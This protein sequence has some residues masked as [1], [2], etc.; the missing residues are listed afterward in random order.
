MFT[1]VSLRLPALLAALLLLVTMAA[2]DTDVSHVRIVRLSYVSG[3]VQVDQPGSAGSEKALLNMP[4]VEGMT[5]RTGDDGEAELE[6][7]S[8]TAVRVA[9][10]SQLDIPQLELQDGRKLTTV[11][12]ED[13]TAYVDYRQQRDSAFI[14]GY[15]S[16]QLTL[17]KTVRFR[18]EVDGNEL[19]LAVFKGSLDVA[20]TDRDVRV[21]KN[22]TATLFADDPERYELADSI[23]AGE[24]DDWNKEREQYVSYYSNEARQYNETYSYSYGASDLAYFGNSFY[25]PGYGYCWRPYGVGSGWDPFADGAWVWYPGFGYTWV[26]AYPWGWLPYRYGS[27]TFVPSY[28]WLWFPQGSTSPYTWR[29]GPNL[30]NPR[31]GYQPPKPPSA[32]GAVATAVA[33]GPTVVPVG[34]GGIGPVLPGHGQISPDQLAAI[35]ALRTKQGLAGT[36]LGQRMIL[37][38]RT[39]GEEGAVAA[40]R[41]GIG[42]AQPQPGVRTPGNEDNDAA[43]RAIRSRAGEENRPATAGRVEPAQ[44]RSMPAPRVDRSGPRPM[45]APRVER[46]EPRPAPMPS[47]RVERSEPRVYSPPPSPPPSAPARSAPAPSRPR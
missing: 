25:V 38:S 47:P 21:K 44:P 19:Q 20:G 10:G 22:E 5:I 37:R 34:R 15:G 4:V 23:A 35:Q 30:Y 9:P 17:D 32:S 31:P 7:E 8:G 29:T 26:S 40:G 14:F 33:S 13:G 12:L 43:S 11:N 3:D 6:F 18:A 46:A 45:P 1:H 42:G 41:T 16:H 24:Y 28:G 2:A 39:G 36:D 27:W